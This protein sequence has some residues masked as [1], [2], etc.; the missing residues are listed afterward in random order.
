ME[1]EIET[2]ARPIAAFEPTS[3]ATSDGVQR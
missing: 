1:S 3:R 2:Y